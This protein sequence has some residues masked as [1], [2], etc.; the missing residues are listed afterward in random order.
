MSTVL[1]GLEGVD[2]KVWKS[3]ASVSPC[4]K[5]RWSQERQWG[6]R[7]SPLVNFIMLNPS[8]ADAEQDDPTV[9]GCIQRA[10]RW[11]YGRLVVTNLFAWRAT[12]PS[13][14]SKVEDPIGPSND[15][16]IL[17]EAQR[18]NV[19]VCAWGTKGG[20]QGRNERVLKMLREA[21]VALFRLR[22]TKDG[23]PEHPLYIPQSQ[24]P[25]PWSFWL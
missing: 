2:G 24:D 13:A 6:P 23:H 12:D 14:L 25:E 21:D 20:L 9:R 8:T 22:L 18:A 17:N 16:V 10:K 3:E 1:P 19:V 11:D 15:L 5:Y 7:F 4:G